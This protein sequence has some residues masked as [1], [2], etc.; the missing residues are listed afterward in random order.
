MRIINKALNVDPLKRYQSAKEMLKEIERKAVFRYNWQINAKCWY[1]TI[2][3]I[4]Y[5]IE[6]QRS[7]GLCDVI[8]SKKRIDSDNLRRILKILF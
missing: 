2:N 3:N 1:A 8:T 4:D 7:S 6:I 5:K